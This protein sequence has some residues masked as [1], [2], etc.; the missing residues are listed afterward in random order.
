MTK[1]ILQILILHIFKITVQTLTNEYILCSLNPSKPC[2]CCN[3]QSFRESIHYITG[4]SFTAHYGENSIWNFMPKLGFVGNASVLCKSFK[5]ALVSCHETILW[6]CQI[7]QP[8][9]YMY[10]TDFKALPGD[11]ALK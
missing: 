10:F 6:A 5:R 2:K 11:A 1:K 8:K 3:A 9:L 7:C 4:S